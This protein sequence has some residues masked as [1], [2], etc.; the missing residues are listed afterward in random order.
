M[1]PVVP[2][3]TSLIVNVSASWSTDTT[4]ASPEMPP[5]S[6][7]I[8]TSTDDASDVCTT[9]EPSVTWTDKERVKEYVVGERVGDAVGCF[10]GLREGAGVGALTT[11]VGAKVG[12]LV[13]AGDGTVVG[14]GVGAFALKVG[15]TV[16]NAVGSAD[17]ILLGL[18][19]GCP[20]A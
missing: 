20:P 7:L 3:T 6:T 4:N 15:A 9:A 14:A 1:V 5:P 16:G 12:L 17:G 18:G 2:V 13:G 11:K 8:K 10:V 19:V